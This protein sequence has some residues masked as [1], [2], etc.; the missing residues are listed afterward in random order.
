MDDA[1]WVS[2]IN[3]SKAGDASD[4]FTSLDGVLS[5]EASESAMIPR[6]ALIEPARPDLHSVG[7]T[8]LS[9]VIV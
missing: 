8:E 7:Y 9:Q 5:W 6:L 2:L 1:G 3:R 4:S